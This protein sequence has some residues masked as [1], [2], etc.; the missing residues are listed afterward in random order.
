MNSELGST[1]RKYVLIDDFDQT[2][3]F[4][5]SGLVLSELLGIP[6]FL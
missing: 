2:L 1:E 3:S 5:G 6:N 4:N